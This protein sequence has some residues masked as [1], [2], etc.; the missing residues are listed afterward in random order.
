MKTKESFRCSQFNVKGKYWK[1]QN[2][3]SIEGDEKFTAE[4][5]KEKYCIRRDGPFTPE[6]I[7]EGYCT[8]G[9][10]QF[11]SDERY[12]KKETS[13]KGK[14]VH[15]TQRITLKKLVY[16][17]RKVLL[18]VLQGLW[19][20]VYWRKKTVEIRKL[21][22]ESSTKMFARRENLIK[23]SI[24]DLRTEKDCSGERREGN[25]LRKLQRT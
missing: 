14:T 9:D 13:L 7:R 19:Q 23:G 16:T 3:L 22:G 24:T 18:N 25:L 21:Y 4:E 12:M 2:M 17:A 6:W 10:R 20:K 5:R 1:R 15:V 8:K 11:T